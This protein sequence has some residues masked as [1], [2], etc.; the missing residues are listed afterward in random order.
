[1]RR[2]ILLVTLPSLLAMFLILELTFRFIIPA[3]QFPYYYYDQNDRILRF[4]TTEQREGVFT[5]GYLAQQRA[6]WRIN[7]AGWIV[8]LTSEKQR[9]S[10]VSLFWGFIC[11][12][13]RG[14]CWGFPC[15]T[16]EENGISGYRSL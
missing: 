15:W 16:I 8:P 11:R 13:A 10:Y 14:Q 2:N 3:S 9:A 5:I 6:R 4:A 1:M 7:N 12:G